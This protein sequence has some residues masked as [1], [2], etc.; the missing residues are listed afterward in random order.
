MKQSVHIYY[1]VYILQ[2][3]LPLGAKMIFDFTLAD[4]CEQFMYT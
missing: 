1:T 2:K 3:Y 4:L